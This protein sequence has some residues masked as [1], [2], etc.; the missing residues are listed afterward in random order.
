MTVSSSAVPIG[1]TVAIGAAVTFDDFVVTAAVVVTIACWVVT[2]TGSGSLGPHGHCAFTPNKQSALIVHF[3]S[4]FL[5]FFCLAVER[6][7]Y[8]KF[9]AKK[10]H[11]CYI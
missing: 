9:P 8:V 2:I 11:T 3:A 4:F 7:T 6:L 10:F 5:K 1:G